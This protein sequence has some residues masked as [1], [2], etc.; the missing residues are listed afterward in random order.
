M[1]H[2][3]PKTRI[4]TYGTEVRLRRDRK[5]SRPALTKNWGGCCGQDLPKA[6]PKGGRPSTAWELY[7]YPQERRRR[8]RRSL[9]KRLDRRSALKRED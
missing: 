2:H 7:Y 1:A 8:K 3:K 5:S 9:E 6:D 4:N